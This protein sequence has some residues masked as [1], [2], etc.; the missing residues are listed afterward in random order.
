MKRCSPRSV[1]MVGQILLWSVSAGAQGAVP[2][3]FT[4][5][6]T[7]TFQVFLVDFQGSFDF[8]EDSGALP[9]TLPFSLSNPAC[10]ASGT[11]TVAYANDGIEISVT[12]G[13]LTA[14]A[15]P[16][17]CDLNF[18]F[19]GPV[20]FSFA[21]P[22]V[23]EPTT[24]IVFSLRATSSTTGGVQGFT[25]VQGGLSG[26]PVMFTPYESALLGFVT[27]NPNIVLATG[28]PG[29]AGPISAILH[30]VPDDIVT[31]PSA[32]ASNELLRGDFF[33]PQGTGGTFSGVLRLE[34][35]VPPVGSGF[36]RG[37]R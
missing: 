31:Y 24:P 8:V 19:L 12:G 34:A 23:G 15:V 21:V 20:D 28:L 25:D 6:S 26:P 11:A 9:L 17:G 3:P 32:A 36:G 4:I 29:T 13:S 22:D 2:V 18:I 35:F 30:Y 14:G 1:L 10:T 5:G 37:G 16:N 27:G 33:T 7:G